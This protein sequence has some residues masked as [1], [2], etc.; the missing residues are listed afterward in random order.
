MKKQVLVTG[1]SRGIGREIALYL[2][3]SGYDVVAHYN[4]T[5]IS[6]LGI[7]ALKFDIQ[8]TKECRQVLEKD[9]QEHGAYYG[10]V[11]NAGIARDNVFPALESD[12]WF[13]VLN[14][15]LGGFYN[16]LK[17]VVMPMI[18]KRIKGRI[19]AL[20][21]VS[22]LSGNRG[23]TNYAASKAGVIGA[24]K[25]LSLEL[26]K[27]GITVNSVAPGLI[28]TDMTKDLPLDEIKKHIPMKRIGKPRE[29]ASLVNYLMGE[30]SS[31][32]TGQVISVNGGL[33]L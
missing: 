23:Q 29:V 12:E 6:N 4:S 13:D 33:Y 30:D 8:N 16:V 11:L 10:V 22:A 21:S 1:S 28:E 17:P 27:R 15:N 19:V 25:S 9:I 26:A 31:Y 32:I 24:V 2:E 3:S 5:P 18:E 14:T 20:S 7:R